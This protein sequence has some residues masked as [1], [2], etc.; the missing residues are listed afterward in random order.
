MSLTAI[1]SEIEVIF[2]SKL[3]YPTYYYVELEED[4]RTNVIIQLKN[5]YCSSVFSYSNSNSKSVESFAALTFFTLADSLID[6]RFPNL[7]GMSLV[8]K[9]RELRNNADMIVKIL[10]ESFRILRIVRNAVVHSSSQIL[11]DGYYLEAT[12]I[13]TNEEVKIK[14][15]GLKKLYT[16]ILLLIKILEEDNHS[17]YTK[18]LLNYY[19]NSSIASIERFRDQIG[20]RSSLGNF[21]PASRALSNHLR[22][23]VL[24]NP[25]NI[26]NN[27]IFLEDPYHPPG[28]ESSFYRCDYMITYNGEN[29]LLPEE[30]LDPNN[31]KIPIAEL[32]NWKFDNFL[33]TITKLS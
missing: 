27:E 20:N 1:S 21:L 13:G 31:Y 7:E 4:G 9:C 10:S 24:N 18:W 14:I 8:R 3:L 5:T 25:F 33:K 11:S 30:Y 26:L 2:G 15:D 23:L 6:N 29:F 12:T 16:I 32:E 19:L 22:Q 28:Q 17:E